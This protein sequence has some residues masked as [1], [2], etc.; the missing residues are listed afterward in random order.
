MGDGV[1]E[2]W[3]RVIAGAR[4]AMGLS[5][6]RIAAIERSMDTWKVLPETREMVRQ[7]RLAVARAD[8]AVALADRQF[9]TQHAAGWQHAEQ[10]G[11]V[12][13]DGREWSQ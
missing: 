8:E 3:P 11:K 4:Q 5:R 13:G 12:H 10:V 7:A 2:V 1:R 9:R 6:T